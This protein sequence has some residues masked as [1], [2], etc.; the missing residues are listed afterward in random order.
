MVGYKQK[1]LIELLN[2]KGYVN[3]DDVMSIFN[4]NNTLGKKHISSLTKIKLLKRMDDYIPYRF[5]KGDNLDNYL[6]EQN[7]KKSIRVIN[8]ITNNIRLRVLRRDDYTCVRCPSQM[9]LNIHHKIKFEFG[10]SN[11]I[12]NLE[13]LCNVCHTK[14]HIEN[15]Y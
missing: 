3:L 15:G 13:T 8:D 10:G 14:H 12:D 4:C 5:S 11:N 2:S 9:D 7:L 6:L 1:A